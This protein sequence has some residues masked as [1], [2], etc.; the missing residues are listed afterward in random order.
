MLQ[1]QLGTS[2]GGR[3]WRAPGGSGGAS[4]GGV[5]GTRADAGAGGTRG[6]AGSDSAAANAFVYF[7]KQANGTTTATLAG[8]TFSVNSSYGTSG[9]GFKYVAPN[10][11][12][13]VSNG[14]ISFPTPMTGDFSITA[15][16]TV[17]T[18]NKAN[19]ACGIGVGLTT[20]F[21]G[22]DAYAYVLMRNSNN[23]TNGY[24]VSAA[25]RISA[26]A[27]TVAFT[28]GTPLQLTF[29]RTGSNVSYSAGPVGGTPTTNTVAASL[30]TNGTA[31]YGTGPV[32]P[33]ISFNNVAATI[34]NLVIKDA[35]GAVVYDSAT[36]TLVNYIPAVAHA[37]GEHRR[38]EQGRGSLGDRNGQRARRSGV[39]RDGG[40]RRSDHRHGDGHQRRD[41]LDDHAQRPQGRR[42]DGDRHQQR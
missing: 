4:T 16:V 28:N 2:A 31:V 39:G 7:V 6:D 3:G 29:A 26:G 8:G 27:P 12:G 23:S 14:F 25:G 11:Y 22:T 13:T 42:H 36:G 10:Y 35:G 37:L 41:Q 30:L 33:A 5:G 34:T 40:R 21:A 9:N 32:Y 15:Q 1:L 38:L 18:Q 17:T 20:G 19:N 24:A